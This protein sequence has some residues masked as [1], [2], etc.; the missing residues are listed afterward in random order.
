MPNP[1]MQC[2]K[3]GWRERTATCRQCSAVMVTPHRR[4]AADLYDY[5]QEDYARKRGAKSIDE[6]L[7]DPRRRS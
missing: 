5:A 7:D 3:C 4:T 1:L 2:P 6:V